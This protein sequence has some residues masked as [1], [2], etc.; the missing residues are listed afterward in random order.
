M[1]GCLKWTKENEFLGKTPNTLAGRNTMAVALCYPRKGGSSDMFQHWWKSV[2]LYLLQKFS[3]SISTRSLTRSGWCQ[4][5]INREIMWQQCQHLKSYHPYFFSV[6]LVG[7]I[8]TLACSGSS[9]GFM[10]PTPSSATPWLS[11]VT[12]CCSPQSRCPIKCQ[13]QPRR[14]RSENSGR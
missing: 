14:S 1:V 6:V 9:I 4:F 7:S 2:F 11:S 10:A 13:S 12:S 5:G 8:R 3:K